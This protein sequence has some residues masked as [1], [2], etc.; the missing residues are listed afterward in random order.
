MA[1]IYK[2][3]FSIFLLTISRGNGQFPNMFGGMSP[4]MM[5]SGMFGG[6]NPMMGMGSG[7]MSAMMSGMGGGMGDPLLAI[8]MSSIELSATDLMILNQLV[9]T[10]VGPQATVNT[11]LMVLY[12]TDGGLPFNAYRMIPYITIMQGMAKD[13]KINVPG[14]QGEATREQI[15]NYIL[16]RSIQWMQSRNMAG[17]FMD[18]AGMLMMSGAFGNNMQEPAMTPAAANTASSAQ[19][20]ARAAAAARAAFAQFAAAQKTNATTAAATTVV[21][22]S[23][24]TQPAAVPVAAVAPA[25]PAAP[26]NDVQTALLAR[27]MSSSASTS[28]SSPSL[29]AGLSFP[30]GMPLPGMS[31]MSG[32]NFPGM[33][34]G[35]GSGGEAAAGNLMAMGGL[36]LMGL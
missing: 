4:S 32:F 18:N 26:L 10:I 8:A 24:N 16:Q 12:N 1:G 20:T 21:A 14:V 30:P 3:T 17:A 7:M 27:L 23:T 15:D 13:L 33:S 22:S 25:A 11:A 36:E 31:G 5:G 9:Q 6:M 28:S 34:T 29:P 2:I 19:A 35:M